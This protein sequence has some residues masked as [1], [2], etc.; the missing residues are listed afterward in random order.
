M[1]MSFWMARYLPSSGFMS[2]AMPSLVTR[3]LLQA[4]MPVGGELLGDL[5]PYVPDG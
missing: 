3:F 1:N 4:G 5:I 2:G